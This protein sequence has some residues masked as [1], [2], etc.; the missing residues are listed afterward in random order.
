MEKMRTSIWLAVCVSFVLV[1]SVCAGVT[2]YDNTT[3]SG[4]GNGL[5]L[6]DGTKQTTALSFPYIVSVSTGGNS[7]D[8]T[9]GGIGSTV[10]STNTGTTGPAGTF[11]IN[12]AA[13]TA[14]ALYVT[15][16]GTKGTI[17]SINTGTGNAG[18]FTVNTASSTG[19]AINASSN[20]THA[21]IASTNSGTAPAVMGTS[22]GTGVA[23]SFTVSNL[24]NNVP[25]VMISSNGTGGNLYAT[26][27]GTAGQAGQFIISN[28]SNTSTALTAST[29]GSGFGLY[30]VGGTGPIA[31]QFMGNVQTSG[32]LAVGGML[33]KAAG[34]FKIDHPLDPQNKYLF[35]SFV[36]SPDMMN[37]YNGN[38]VTD[39]Q[40]Y[41]TINMPDWFEALNSEFR[42]QLTV[43][44]KDS[45]ARARIFNEIT[46]N[47][48]VIQTDMPNIKVSWQV[49]GIRHD[50]YAEKYRI[51]VEVDKTEAEKGKCMFPEACL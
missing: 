21:T 33:S 49:T 36:E 22:T 32:N 14:N 48:F 3:I 47:Q 41:A 19:N 44:G 24:T 40:G 6:P 18:A 15:S 42:Y 34:T 1:S 12:N 10:N 11:T 5:V 51:Q 9:N 27:T 8:I 39:A 23:A 13:S 45:W 38:T 16:N 35:H 26:N 17:N 30:V 7:F 50:A 25:A 46:N 20:G 43:I 28:S 31:A 37:I 29:N 2:I 4:D